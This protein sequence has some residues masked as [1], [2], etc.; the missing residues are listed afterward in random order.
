MSSGKWQI[1]GG[2]RYPVEGYELGDPKEDFTYNGKVWDV[3]RDLT[4]EE[5]TAIAGK[6]KKDWKKATDEELE[7]VSASGRIAIA[8]WPGGVRPS[9]TIIVNLSEE[10][11]Q[12]QFGFID[13][14]PLLELLWRKT[15]ADCPGEE[16]D[17][18][19]PDGR[20]HIILQ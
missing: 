15:G 8:R 18:E 19:L 12:M 13:N 10:K 14:A 20:Y 4:L 17:L 7:E 2:V 11:T 3:V 1:I 16:E 5:A 9:K 6:Q